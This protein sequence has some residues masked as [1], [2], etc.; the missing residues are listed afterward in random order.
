MEKR[1]PNPEGQVARTI[2]QSWG[3]IT[4]WLGT[5]PA[6]RLLQVGDTEGLLRAAPWVEWM[7]AL[8]AV[9]APMARTVSQNALSGLPTSVNARMD[10]STI[11]ALSVQYAETQA[12]QL[13]TALSDSA[14]ETVR[15]ILGGSLRGEYTGVS[16]ARRLRDVIGLHP[17]WAEAVEAT[18]E[19]SYRYQVAQGKAESKAREMA[20]RAAAAQAKRLLKRRAENVA[21]TEIIT[22]E[23]L[24]RFASWNEAVAQG[25]MGRNA[26]KEWNTEVGAACDDCKAMDGEIARWDQPFSNGLLM[27]PGHPSCRCAASALPAGYTAGEKGYDAELDD[28]D[29][30]YGP[31]YQSRVGWTPQPSGDIQGVPIRAT[32]VPAAPARTMSAEKAAEFIDQNFVPGTEQEIQAAGLYLG[33]ARYNAALR[34]GDPIDE[35]TQERIDQLNSYIRKQPGLPEAATV[36]RGMANSWVPADLEVGG[37]FEEP[38]FMSTSLK[39]SEAQIFAGNVGT[40]FETVLPPGSH[41]FSVNHAT[42]RDQSGVPEEYREKREALAREAEVLLPSGSRHRVLSIEERIVDG[43]T[44]QWVRVQ[45]DPAYVSP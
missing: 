20:D 8:G 21:R 4:D 18:R 2:N 38:A 30:L 40:I 19:R 36:Y 43:T 10:F 17:R 24:G 12:G 34:S 42:L 27:P 32:P 41:A 31:E 7:A 14:R 1:A 6:T 39:L 45:Y 29:H 28:P 33:G 11:D 23:N 9:R 16:A 44:Y 22:S 37:T 5:T 3:V 26:R 35:F 13:I 25:V 15:T